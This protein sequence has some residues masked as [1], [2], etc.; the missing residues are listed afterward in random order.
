LGARTEIERLG[1]AACRRLAATPAAF[2]RLGALCPGD[3]VVAAKLRAQFRQVQDAVVVAFGAPPVDGLGNTGGFK[4]QVQDRAD[5]GPEAL[6]GAVE[7]V[8][9]RNASQP[10]LV[11]LFSTF[12][13]SQ[14]QLYLDVDRAKAKALGVSLNDVF[15]TLQIYLGSS[16]A[17]DFTRFG[18]NWQVNLKA[19]ST[20]RV[21]HDR[22]I[23]LNV[24]KYG[25]GAALDACTLYRPD[26]R[27]TATTCSRLRNRRRY[28]S[29]VSRDRRSRMMGR[30]DGS[31]PTM[32]FSGRSSLQLILAGNTA[33]FVFILG[34]ILVFMVLRRSTRLVAPGRDHPDRADVPPR[35][36]RRRV[37]RR[38][39]QH[40]HPDRPHR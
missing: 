20:Y 4:M 17:N 1:Q 16:Y 14:P 32:S 34:A 39:R 10:G 25:H 28:G 12:R 23:Q 31:C 37:G 18:R 9:R 19:D 36:H 8:I 11:G 6:Q 15:Q 30:Y 13:A 7:N 2:H 26:P 5:A 21:D 24:S 3:S 29:G 27:R 35:R 38:L 40:L 33:V 22:N